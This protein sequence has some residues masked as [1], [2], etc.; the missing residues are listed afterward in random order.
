MK[1]YGATLEELGVPD[2]LTVLWYRASLAIPSRFPGRRLGLW[3]AGADRDVQVWVNGQ[4]VEAE[5]RD[6]A[7]GQWQKSLVAKSGPPVQ[8]DITEAVQF[9]RPNLLA[10]KVDHR[11]MTDLAL[12][13]LVKPVMVYAAA[14]GQGLYHDPEP[15]PAAK[16]K[17]PAQAKTPG[18]SRKTKSNDK[19][20]AK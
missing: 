19:G 17:K 6:R 7:T 5:V 3:F 10:L 11:A 8:F 15:A 4:P 9:D 13:G 16:A 2:K 18:G 14:P 20:K 1:T 12:G